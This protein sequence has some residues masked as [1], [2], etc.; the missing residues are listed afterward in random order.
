VGEA[1]EEEIRGTRL[2]HTLVNVTRIQ[3]G[4][5]VLARKHG[6]LDSGVERW[7]GQQ[8]V[9]WLATEEGG[10]KNLRQ[11]REAHGLGVEMVGIGEQILLRDRIQDLVP[12]L[13]ADT[14]APGLG[15]QHGDNGK[16]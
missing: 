5:M 3:E 6:G 14:K 13:R 9:T 2:H 4:L 16:A 1:A 12:A 10:N 11:G 8:R 7:E 15:P